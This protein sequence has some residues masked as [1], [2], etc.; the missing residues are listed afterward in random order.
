MIG[1][2]SNYSDYMSLC[3]NCKKELKT[4]EGD[5]WDGQ[6]LCA[7]CLKQTDYHLF[8]NIHVVKTI[9]V[10]FYMQYNFDLEEKNQFIQ[11]TRIKCD[12]CETSFR[13][14]KEQSIEEEVRK[15]FVF[16]KSQRETELNVK[17][18]VICPKCNQGKLVFL[19]NEEKYCKKHEYHIATF[20][21][22]QCDNTDC[23]SVEINE[24]QHAKKCKCD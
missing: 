13:I 2:D 7:S 21:M 5:E 11:E 19:R 24:I 17:D 20:K 9:D 3:D 14:T 10:D 23:N 4:F 18:R 16:H 12:I 22:F 1:F 8:R 15:H 6:Y